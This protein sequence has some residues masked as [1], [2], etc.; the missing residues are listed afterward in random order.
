MT[1]Q[2]AVQA[3]LNNYA[4]FSGR[5]RRSEFWFWVLAIVILDVVVSIIDAIIG[6]GLLAV[7]VGLGLIVPNIAVG[8]RRLHDTGR[9]GWWQL[10]AFIPIVG[11]V[12]LI[13]WWATEGVPG[14]NEH[15]PNPKGIGGTPMAGYGYPPP[16]V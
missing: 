8:C 12:L 11:I 4:G 6:S 16:A 2:Q 10:I 5:A 3:V 15:G 7:L 9:S 13:V 14:D 1:L